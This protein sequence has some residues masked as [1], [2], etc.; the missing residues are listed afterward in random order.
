MK[1]KDYSGEKIIM[2]KY[3]V[4]IDLGGTKIIAGVVNKETGEVVGHAKKHT[5]KEKGSDIVIQ[6]V[7]ETIEKA[8][9]I[10]GIPINQID[11]IGIGAAG[12]VDR[13]NGV[14]IA[15]PNLNCYDLELK[16]ILEEHF[17]M[18]V[19][20]GNDVEVATLGEMKFGNGVGYDNF[21]CVFVG[22]GIG[23]GIVNNGHQI[24]GANGT[25]G[26]IGHMIVA[27]GGRA[28]E[29]GAYGCLEAYA[30]RTAIEKRIKSELKR[31]ANSVISSIIKEDESNNGTIR[32][33]HMKKALE[34]GDDLVLCCINEASDYLS[35]G[36]ASVI[37]FMNPQVIILG[38]GLVDSIDYFYDITVKRTKEKALP[39]A[40]SSL[41]ITKA[42]LGD[43]AG[44][45]G[46]ALL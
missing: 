26:E 4:G 17:N 6:R 22:T 36:L 32:S 9:C 29:C 8:I 21:L 44:V 16:R 10:A 30:S 19:K 39:T 28:C 24:L 37:N 35:S 33:S 40:V 12:Q 45:V 13:E 1:V 27:E 46:A 20:V 38:G 42:K 5:K 41:K 23:S 31:G 11:S 2:G 7:F 18:P 43:F 15:S 14:L 34:Q 25:A 3:S